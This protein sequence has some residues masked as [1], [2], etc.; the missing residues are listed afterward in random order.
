MCQPSPL[1]NHCQ[2]AH[3]AHTTTKSRRRSL[4]HL[5]TKGRSKPILA[6]PS[7]PRSSKPN[8]SVLSNRLAI[9]FRPVLPLYGEE[10]Q[11]IPAYSYLLPIA[12]GHCWQDKIP[13]GIQYQLCHLSC[14]SSSDRMG[15]DKTGFSPNTLISFYLAVLPFGFTLALVQQ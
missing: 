12:L 14:S 9:S 11:P 10:Q 1:I 4:E 15:R 13:Q 7:R 6:S 8:M 2:T 5:T 3:N